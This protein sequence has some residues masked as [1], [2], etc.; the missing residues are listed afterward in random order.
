MGVA[1]SWTAQLLWD[2]ADGGSAGEWWGNFISDYVNTTFTAGQ[3]MPLYDPLTFDL[4]GDGIETLPLDGQNSVLFDHNADGV[5]TATGWVSPD[6]GFLV[7]DLDGNGLIDTGRE[8]FGDNTLLSNG[9]LAA[10]GFEALA[11]LD[12][13]ADGVIDVN[14]AAFAQ[15]RIWRDANSDGVTQA[16]ELLTLNETGI[17]SINTDFESASIDQNGNTISAL[18]S[19][20]KTDGASSTLGSVTSLGNLDLA[21][22]TFYSEF[23]DPVTL[24]PE[25]EALPAMQGSGMVRDMREAASL[26]PDFA[27]A[28]TAYASLPTRET[29]LAALDNLLLKWS[30][31]SGMQTMI[32]RALAA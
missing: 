19:Y 25:A 21:R 5:K 15:L 7:R 9:T 20:T 26:D 8:L 4:D 28:L 29:Q 32:D 13:N 30:E 11:D 16:G 17:V 23:T 14:D 27:A 24:T 6:D 2:I 10:N 1:G 22:S 12:A 18:G 31:T 3:A